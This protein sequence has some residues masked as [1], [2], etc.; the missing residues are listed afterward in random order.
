MKVLR[1]PWENIKIIKGPHGKAK[2]RSGGGGTAAILTTA[3]FCAFCLS[4]SSTENLPID[5]LSL[6]LGLRHSEPTVNCKPRSLCSEKH[7]TSPMWLS[8]IGRLTKRPLFSMFQ[9]MTCLYPWPVQNR[10]CIQT[11]CQS[12]CPSSSR[13]SQRKLRHMHFKIDG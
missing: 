13:S 11:W 7:T 1:N 6:T 3:A 2:W 5:S 12:C 9:L 10:R 4:F 8:V